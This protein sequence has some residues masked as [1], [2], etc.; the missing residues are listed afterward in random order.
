MS[1]VA[2]R[3][4]TTRYAASARSA[5]LA[6]CL[7]SCSPLLELSKPDSIDLL[8]FHPGILRD[9]VL[10]KLGPPLA[11]APHQE[12]VCDFY[13]VYTT[14]ARVGV[15]AGVA[16]VEAAGDVATLGLSEAVFTPAELIA[17]YRQKNG[18]L[19]LC[20]QPKTGRSECSIMKW[21]R[22]SL[23]STY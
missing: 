11:S 4:S 22:L 20:C 10:A 13:K 18:H 21:Q 2:L 1:L 16:L 6:A 19:L 8:E 3:A 14:T 17:P 9:T 12:Q 7:C 15:R 5:A 23:L